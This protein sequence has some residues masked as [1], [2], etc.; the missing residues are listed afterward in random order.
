ME[1]TLSKFKEKIEN[2]LIIIENPDLFNYEIHCEIIKEVLS[3]S[4]NFLKDLNETEIKNIAK[5]T[6]FHKEKC[7]KFVGYVVS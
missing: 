7:K 6:K 1:K 4:I 2:T 5:I 3:N